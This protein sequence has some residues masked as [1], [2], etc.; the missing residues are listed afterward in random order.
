MAR[1]GNSVFPDM[2]PDDPTCSQFGFYQGGKPTPMMEKSLL[3]KLTQVHF[4]SITATTSTSFLLSFSY[5][6]SHSFFHSFIPVPLPPP[7]PH[8]L[9]WIDCSLISFSFLLFTLN[10]SHLLIY[11][12]SYLF[13][14]SSSDYTFYILQYGVRPGV[15]LSPKRYTHAFTSR[16]GKCRI[17]KIENV[18]EES[19]KWVMDPA[20]RI[21]DAPGSWHCR[22]Q[23]PPALAPLIAK[24][25]DFAQLEDFNKKK[26]ETEEAKKYQEAYHARMSGKAPASSGGK[27]EDD[28][29]DDDNDDDDYEEE[30]VVEEG[31]R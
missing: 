20:N 22:G 1:I 16:F 21:C 8:R 27:E 25:K 5:S 11:L 24:R 9:N 6:F 12:D 14:S 15:E 19:K 23:Y 18:S 7:P 29:D 4:L 17:F 10:L 13:F 2:C 28:G 31:G 30:E 26:K 3:F